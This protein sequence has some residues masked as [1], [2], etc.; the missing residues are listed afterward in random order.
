MLPLKVFRPYD[1]V[2]TRKWKKVFIP[3]L[4]ASISLGITPSIAASNMGGKCTKAGVFT[5]IG[6]KVAICSKNG[7]KMI[8]TLATPAQKLIF[9]KQQ[10]QLLVT[11]RKKTITDLQS[12]KEQYSDMTNRIAPLNIS[13]IETKKLLIEDSRNM[14]IDLQKQKETTQQTKIANQN[15]LAAYNNSISNAQNN[16][17]SLANQIS[18][19]QS[20]VNYLKINNDSSYNAYVSAK[21][22]SDYLSYS[23]QRALSDNSAM[24]SSKVLCDFGFGYCGIYSAAQYS[25][26]SSIISQ[27]NSA[28]ARTSGAYASYASYNSQYSSN[29]NA[30]NSLK[31]Q[32]TQFSN[33]I[34]S[35]NSQKSQATQNISLAESRIANLE[36][37]INQAIGK[38]SPLENAEKRIEQ[39]LQRYSEIKGLIE[40]QSAAYVVE[41]DTFLTIADEAFVL[42]ASTANWNSKYSVL[43]SSQKDIES[44]LAE[45]KTLISV[46]ESFLNT[47]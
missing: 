7:S 32:Q 26:N 33:S 24:L 43:T 21:A 30:L 25:Y 34:S 1:D 16:L 13:L 29:L 22:Q 27:Y 41:I 6:N 44:K 23:Y 8:W 20:T 15:N 28:S 31:A 40:I 9:Q 2:M 18:S 42:S 14:L 10:L 11:S 38:F 37:L 19:Q 5:Q 46:L 17:N 12:A 35:L 47:L 3:L 45:I 4:L 36:I 39:D